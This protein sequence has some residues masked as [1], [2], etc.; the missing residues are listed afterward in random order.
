VKLIIKSK[1]FEYDIA[2]DSKIEDLKQHVCED[3]EIKEEDLTLSYLGI[4]LD[5]SKTV[6]GHELSSGVLL[7]ASVS[8]DIFSPRF[9]QTNSVSK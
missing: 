6:K 7:S 1:L 8:S 2:S 4:E 3:L 5:N 9:T